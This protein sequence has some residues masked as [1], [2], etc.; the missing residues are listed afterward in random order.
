MEEN[1][2]KEEAERLKTA[3]NDNTI[4]SLAKYVHKVLDMHSLDCGYDVNKEVCRSC[5]RRV[6]K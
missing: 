2:A 3:M 1:E 6:K 4:N 5:A